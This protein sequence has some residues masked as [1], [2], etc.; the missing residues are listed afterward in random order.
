MFYLTHFCEFL[1][2]NAVSKDIEEMK[3]DIK[4]IKQLTKIV[5]PRIVF[6]LFA[7]STSA[8]K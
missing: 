8:N 2:V 6:R 3:K 4:S 7:I 5:N 1:Y